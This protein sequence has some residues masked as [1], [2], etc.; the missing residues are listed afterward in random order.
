MNNELRP[1]TKRSI[2][3]NTCLFE[4]EEVLLRRAMRSLPYTLGSQVIPRTL[5]EIADYVVQKTTTNAQLI[6]I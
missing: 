1:L 2:Y 3:S 6:L 5:R 4:R